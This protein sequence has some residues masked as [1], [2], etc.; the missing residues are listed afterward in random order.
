MSKVYLFDWG[1]TLMVDYKEQTGH[2]KDWTTVKEVD[3]ALQTLKVLSVCA[4]VFVATGSPGTTPELM[5]LAFSRSNLADY[6]HG[7][8]CPSNVG[9]DK[10]S[11]HFYQTI[12]AR[13]NCDIND[14]CMVGDNLQRD[15]LPALAIGMS[16]IWLNANGDYNTDG[17]N[18]ISSLNELYQ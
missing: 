15:I 10:P 18:E 5:K 12:A 3:G 9:H 1:D 13:V 6:I 14:I 11:A 7:Y 17:V 16:A 4:K 2:M 8:F